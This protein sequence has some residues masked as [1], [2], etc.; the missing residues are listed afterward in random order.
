MCL[1]GIRI[2]KEFGEGL[3]RNCFP[4]F[5]NFGEELFVVC[6]VFFGLRGAVQSVLAVKSLGTSFLYQIQSRP[7]ML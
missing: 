4:Q 5:C 2:V 7:L 3:V 1:D 6:G